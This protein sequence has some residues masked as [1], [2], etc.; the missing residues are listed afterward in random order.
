MVNRINMKPI[1]LSLL[2]TAL[3]IF[4]FTACGQKRALYL[5][6]EPVSNLST[7]DAESSTASQ[8]GKD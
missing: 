8:Q 7:L 3:V 2:L 1:G 4:L 5:P 6:E